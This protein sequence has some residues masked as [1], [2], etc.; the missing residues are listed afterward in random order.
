MST[1]DGKDSLVEDDKEAARKQIDHMEFDLTEKLEYIK[2]K[3][4]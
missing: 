2:K 1:I 4:K 3:I